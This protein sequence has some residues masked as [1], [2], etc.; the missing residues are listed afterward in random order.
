MAWPS[1]VTATWGE[2]VAGG[3]DGQGMI[4]RASRSY[5]PRCSRSGL[6]PLTRLGAIEMSPVWGGVPDGCL[7]EKEIL[8]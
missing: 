5:P 4:P 6:T 7:T 2:P 8:V 1:A 3:V